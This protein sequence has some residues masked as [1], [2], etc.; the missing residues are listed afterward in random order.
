V[1]G[2]TATPRVLV[3]EDEKMILRLYERALQQQGWSVWKV[4]SGEAAVELALQNTFDIAVIDLRLKGKLDGLTTYRV[5]KALQPDLRGIIVTGYGNRQSL[6]DAL[7]MGVDAW[8]EKPVTVTDLVTTVQKVLSRPKGLSLSLPPSPSAADRYAFLR[9]FL[10]MLMAAT[11]SDTAAL[12][13]RNPDDLG[14][15]P[16]ILLGDWGMPLPSLSSEE[17][18]DCLREKLERLTDRL[19]LM[20]PVSWQGQVLGAIALGRRHFTSVPYTQADLVYPDALRQL[21]SAAPCGLPLSDGHCS[22][23]C[24]LLGIAD[25]IVAP[26]DR[27][28]GRAT[29][30]PFAPHRRRTGQSLR[31]LPRPIAPFGTGGDPSRFGESLFA[32]GH[33][34]EAPQPERKRATTHPTTSRLRRATGPP[35]GA[36]QKI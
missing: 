6:L 11:L 15:R 30:P 9:L 1:T 7:R 20:A 31:L 22:Q 29:S 35:V 8:L 14:M 32:E 5:L 19:C 33:L 21:V 24:A 23:P 17:P 25:G 13:M 2:T 16:Q 28:D 36:C 26:A 18:L 27:A 4:T 34:D 3:V 10:Q 12:W